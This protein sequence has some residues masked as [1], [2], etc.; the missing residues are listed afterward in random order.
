MINRKPPFGNEI[1][2]AISHLPYYHLELL[3]T[4]FNDISK[5]EIKVTLKN[6]DKIKNKCTI[7]GGVMNLIVGNNKNDTLLNTKIL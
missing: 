7:Q 1:I 2:E 5:I 3:Q 6:Y 4:D